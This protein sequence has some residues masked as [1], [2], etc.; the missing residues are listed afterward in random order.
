MARSKTGALI[1]ITIKTEL[2][3]QINTGEKLNA[4]ISSSL[5]RTIFFKNS[6]LHDGAVIIKGNRIAAAGCI[7]PLTQREIDEE[8]G[9]R[10]RAAIGIT[11]ISDA[12]CI[13][14]SEQRG[15]VSLAKDGEIR[16]DISKEELISLLTENIEIP[17]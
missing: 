7:L 8:F 2:N 3:E 15:A 12:V 9:L 17:E 16:K 11:E 14:V 6:P 1:V 13:I 5:I 10:H 4:K